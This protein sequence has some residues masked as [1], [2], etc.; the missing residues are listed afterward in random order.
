MFARTPLTCTW[1]APSR[2]A[3]PSSVIAATTPRPS[4]G[5]SPRCSSPAVSIRATVWVTRLRLWHI[6]S[7]SCAIRIC[8]PGASESRTRI[9]YSVSEIRNAAR[10]SLSS[11]S[12]SRVVPIIS[13]RQDRCWSLS[14]HRVESEICVMGGV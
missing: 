2:S 3:K 6:A 11:R 4:S 9:S 13:A 1:A 14:S 5:D 8:R 10:R 7:A 12:S